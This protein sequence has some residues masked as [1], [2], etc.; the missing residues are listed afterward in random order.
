[1]T[2][3]EYHAFAQA[4]YENFPDPV[5]LVDLDRTI[6]AI[7]AAAC[8]HLGYGQEQVVGKSVRM[9]YASESDFRRAVRQTPH[10]FPSDKIFTEG[11]YRYR[12]SDESVFNGRLRVTLVRNA[13]GGI[14]GYVG[15]IHD[16]SDYLEL[17]RQRKR[18]ADIMNAALQAIPEGFAI[19]DA[20]E[21]L[22]VFNEGYRQICGNAGASV[23]IGMSIED[24]IGLV[25]QAGHQPLLP[26]DEGDADQWMERRLRDFRQPPGTPQ[27]YLYSDGRWLRFEDFKSPDGN[28]VCLRI[29]VTELKQAELA[30]D[31]QRQDYQMLVQN[32]PDFICRISTDFT[33]VF[34]NKAY[35]D[36]VGKPDEALVGKPLLDFV[37]ENDRALLLELF[38]SLSPEQPVISREQR[39]LLPDGSDFW[40]FWSNMAVFDNGKLVEYVTAGRDVTALKQQQLRIAQQ[41]TELQRKNEAL[42]QFTGTVSHDLKAPLRHISMFS[43]MLSEDVGK[44]SFDDVPTYTRHLRQS[45]RRMTQLIDSLLEYAQIA[46]R[47][48]TWQD[49]SMAEVI[50]DAILNLGT[51]IREADA[52][53]EFDGLPIVK[54]DPEL[55]KRLCQNLIGNAIKY[56]KDGVRPVIRI[57]CERRAGALRICFQDNGIGIEPRHAKKIFDIFQR[58]HRDESVYAGTGIGLSLAKRIAESHNGDIE[59]DESFS[60]GARFVLTLPDPAPSGHEGA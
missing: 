53:F 30:R 56:R 12:R 28:T 9:L 59:L 4:L 43:E 52:R 55:L 22:V 20:D 11:I 13:A 14:Q 6:L 39:R 47:I 31:R 38:Q 33:Y 7:N 45:A 42:S 46:D 21:R 5:F 36:F 49:V 26:D 54:G 57:Y 16:I 50:S 1:M 17:D 27:V 29:D 58:L 3:S 51:F 10:P 60:E 37:P 32:I 24:I 15:I 41:T 44:G 35:A 25:Y 34:V 19:F 2:D 8:R 23:E 48:E 18:A 40:I